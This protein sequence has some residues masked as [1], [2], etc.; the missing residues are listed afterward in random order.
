MQTRVSA[1]ALAF[2]FVACFTGSTFILRCFLP[3][4]TDS[5]VFAR[6]CDSKDAG[7]PCS[8]DHAVVA[9]VERKT[10]VLK[11]CF[12]SPFFANTCSNIPG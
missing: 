5:A 8:E 12:F 9:F 11:M 2:L 6:H 3:V 7:T 1:L 10:P 4:F